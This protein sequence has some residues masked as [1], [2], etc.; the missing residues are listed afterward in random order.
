MKPPAPADTESYAQALIQEVKVVLVKLEAIMNTQDKMEKKQSEI[1]RAFE[2][3]VKTCRH[4]MRT[5]SEDI[6]DIQT[7]R[8]THNGIEA[9]RKR[10]E[11]ANPKKHNVYA[12]WIYA[13]F[14]AGRFVV[15]LMAY[16]K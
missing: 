3:Q 6:V 10:Q 9:E 14:M 4:E 7:W 8:A 12:N 1:I 16:F 11:D 5:V 2:E 13:A 15:A